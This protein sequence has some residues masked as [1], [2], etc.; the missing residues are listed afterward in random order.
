MASKVGAVAPLRRALTTT[1]L[2][3]NEPEKAEVCD[4]SYNVCQ[5]RQ[6]RFRSRYQKHR[7]SAVFQHAFSSA[8][9]QQVI[10]RTVPVRTHYDQVGIKFI[11]LIQN[12]FGYCPSRLM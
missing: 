7:T 11:S 5:F 10:H 4:L 9:Y 8:S 2:L 6:L 3:A 12:F 1:V